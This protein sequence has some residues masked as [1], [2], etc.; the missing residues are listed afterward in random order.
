MF[1]VYGEMAASHM[2][3]MRRGLSKDY[4]EQQEHWKKLSTSKELVRLKLVQVLNFMD[5]FLEFFE[6]ISCIL[7]FTQ[8]PCSKFTL[9]LRRFNAIS[10][11]ELEQ[12]N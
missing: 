12:K 9:L 2:Q 10:F 6:H 7:I 3:V 4:T 8:L 5:G 11:C 1:E